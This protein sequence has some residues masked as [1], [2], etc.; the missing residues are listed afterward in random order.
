MAVSAAIDSSGNF[1]FSAVGLDGLEASEYTLVTILVDETGSTSSFADQL[2]E[3][4][5]TA[6][7]STRSSPRV[8]NLLIRVVGFST[9]HPGGVRELHGFK[10]II[11][12]DSV[13]DY[14]SIRPMGGTPLFDAVY[15]ALVVQRQYATTLYNGDFLANGLVYI[16]TDGADNCSD[17]TPQDIKQQIADVL[18]SEELESQLTILVGI[19]A[20]QCDT[21]LVAFKDEADLDFY[22][23]AGQVT[24][25]GLAK[26][27]GHIS[28]SI[29]TQSQSLGSGGPSQK[30]SATI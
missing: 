29:A 1:G 28:Q 16:I 9:A 12:I 24:A 13:Q 3:A 18:Q 8:D 10:P 21:E 6:V 23:D 27:A 26:L 30:V 2:R 22:I 5:K 15:E 25:N 20:T 4:V 19:N 11:G 17:K 7:D 14:Q